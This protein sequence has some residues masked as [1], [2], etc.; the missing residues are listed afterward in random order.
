M[1]LPLGTWISRRPGWLSA[2]ILQ[3]AGLILVALIAFGFVIQ[4]MT[5]EMNRQ[6][7]AEK[8]QMVRGALTRD[9][10]TVAQSVAAIAASDEA[11]EHLY[12]RPDGQWLR[13]INTN[14]ELSTFVLDADGRTL[15]AV[16]AG[17]GDRRD[18]RRAVG[19][20]WPA[21]MRTLPKYFADLATRQPRPVFGRFHGRPAI[22]A[23]GA[24][25]HPDATRSVPGPLRYLIAVVPVTMLDVQGVATTFN[26]QNL[27]MRAAGSPTPGKAF[28]ALGEPGRSP[29]AM[30]EWDEHAPGSVVLRRLWFPLL[31]TA[32]V[33]VVLAAAL[34]SRL[35]RSNRTLIERSR[36]ANDSVSQMVGA[37][38]AAEMARC[39]TE[40]A[41]ADV[42]RT[43]RDLQRSQ[44]EQAE[45]ES[46]HR[47]EQAAAARGI[48]QSLS[49]SIGEIAAQLAQDA[50]D[51]D[52][53]VATARD[54]ILLQ[55]EQA[56][57]A[58]ERSATTAA[59]SA[60]I[61]ASL[62]ELLGAVRTIQADSRRHQHAIGTSAAEAA[63]AR[64][65]QAELRE[66]VVAVNEATTMI[67]EIASRTNL[68]ALN[69]AIEASRAGAQG[70]GFAV[71]AT[72]V[73]ALASRASDI[74]ATINS[75]VERIDVTSR[76]TSELVDKLHDLLSSLA[77]S[78]ASSVVAVERHEKEAARI[79]KITREVNDDAGATD[80]AVENISRAVGAL[81][82][83]AHDT[84]LIG[85]Q[86]RRRAAQLT[87][88]LDHFV[89][90]LRR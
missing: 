73:K 59:N 32:I 22:L 52:E 58:R 18:V 55:G 51:L 28:Y 27:T 33:F 3:L 84:Q 89:H 17:T 62:D 44:R 72:E 85:N 43:T 75:A 37:L 79:Q 30:V 24:V 13:T 45:N 10:Q 21:L 77:A 54:A 61:A 46:R 29:L 50:Q 6:G 76:S 90:Q 47:T 5:A 2:A 86:V 83:A 60:G 64:A 70:A 9:V 20:S 78:S 68:L 19:E 67:R 53:R 88:E 4:T 8:L 63:I 41:L 57:S 81:T 16:G 23:G 25:R 65:R 56:Q 26:L 66:E 39:D 71:V 15:A 69:A 80:A 49:G 87:S 7:A 42:E 11:V 40:T 35:V 74:T 1:P 14:E 38:Q 82:T 31:L 12:G 34:A 48:A 36:V